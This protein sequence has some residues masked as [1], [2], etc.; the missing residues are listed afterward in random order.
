M[1]NP[2]ENLVANN[3]KLTNGELLSLAEGLRRI[4]EVKL[5]FKVGYAISRTKATIY[6]RL[7]VIENDRV[8]IV[9]KF[10]GGTDSV[11]EENQAAFTEA[12]N[13]YH[14]NIGSVDLFQ[15]P[16]AWLEKS[17]ATLEPDTI[18]LI[19][20]IFLNNEVGAV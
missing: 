3:A 18:Y 4:G 15:F 7:G 19:N 9:R 16:L 2:E 13:E 14:T 20:P 1:N 5:P 8:E 6:K 11:L 10:A 17:D 12:W